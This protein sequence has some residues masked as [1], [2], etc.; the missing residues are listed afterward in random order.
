MRRF[1]RK[2]RGGVWLPVYGNSIFGN[3]TDYVA[4]NQ[5]SVIVDT[6]NGEITVDAWAPTFDYTENP[7]GTQTNA[8]NETLHDLVTGNEWRLRRIVGKFFASFSTPLYAETADVRPWPAAEVGFGYIVLKTDEE[9]NPLTDINEVN[10]L[11]MESVDDPWIFRRKWIIKNGLV[12]DYL[13]TQSGTTNKDYWHL[14]NVSRH[15][16]GSTAEY[17]SVAD[18]PHIDQ[19][20]NRRISRQERLFAMVATRAFNPTG[21]DVSDWTDYYDPTVYYSLDH[22]FFG[23]LSFARGNRRNASR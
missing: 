20:T 9:G 12:N 3:A 10:P 21:V 7:W 8:G 4:G 18:G 22:R 14:N 16:P 11:V 5:G 1:R 23:G 19:K 2:R 6:T 15:Y 17:G 13:V